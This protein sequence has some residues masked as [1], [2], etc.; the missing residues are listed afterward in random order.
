MNAIERFK[1]HREA[2]IDVAI[3]SDS[4]E[5]WRLFIETVD[6]LYQLITTIEGLKRKMTSGIE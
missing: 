6:A 1:A 5:T 2:L 4:E 3:D